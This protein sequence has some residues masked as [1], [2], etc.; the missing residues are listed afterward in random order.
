MQKPHPS[1]LDDLERAL[2]LAAFLVARYGARFAPI[3]ER[4]EREIAEARRGDPA[5]RAQRILEDYRDAGARK[6]IR[7][8]HP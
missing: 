6:A 1:S 2:A 5:Q 3:L 8:S 4:V 7:S